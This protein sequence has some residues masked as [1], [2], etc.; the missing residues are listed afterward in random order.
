MKKIFISYRRQDSGPF[1]GRIHDQLESK[2][3]DRNVFCD[4]HDIPAGSDFRAVLNREVSQCDV[5][6]AV[7]GR[8]WAGITDAKGNRRL[9]DPNDFVRIEIELAL[10]NPKIIVI[11]VLVDNAVMPVEQDLP[12]SLR[13]LCYRN[14]VKVRPDPDFSNDM[15]NLLRCIKPAPG[16]LSRWQ[17]LFGAAVLIAGIFLFAMFRGFFKDTAA[18]ESVMPS[19]AAPQ[20]Q[21]SP[22]L[23]PA[24]LVEPVEPG[25]ILVLVAQ[26]EKIGS[27]ERDVTR[28][29]VDD[30]INRFEVEVPAANVRIRE[31]EMVITSNTEALKIAEQTQAVL[32]IW[33]QY[34]D[35][36]AT[37]NV[38]LGSLAS[39]P[40][41]ALERGFL[42]RAIN[43]RVKIKNEREETL[44]YQV[45]GSLILLHNAE[46]EMVTQMI[47]ILSFDLLDAPS[48]EMIG[49][50]SAVHVQKSQQAFISD[51]PLALAE[52]NQAID[53]GA[54]N[55]LFYLFRGLLYQ[56]LGDF[57]S[58]D[59]DLDTALLLAPEG[60][61]A[62]YHVKGA[63][64]LILNNLP[65][66]I[67]SYSK[68][69]EHT[70]DDWYPYNQRGYL[71]FL[72]GQ[73][74]LARADIDQ[75]IALKP[76]TEWPYMWSALIALRQ[77]R[78]ED[79]STMMASLF[80]EQP[81]PAFVDRLL[82]ALYGA[83]NAKLLG[84]SMAA[85]G[86]LSLGQYNVVLQDTDNVL[87][88]MPAYPEMYMLRGLSY[89][90][91]DKYADAE[92]AYTQGLTLDPSFTLLH[93]LRAEMRIKSGD[94]AGA[95]EDITAVQQS[96]LA[97]NFSAYLAAAQSGQFSCKQMFKTK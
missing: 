64:S 57:A 56:G 5:V 49:N 55:P 27:Q 30:L 87:A 91:L 37:V 28:F 52:I 85:M 54:D 81:N 69:I 72:A 61:V 80:Q 73:Y 66:G 79:A 42:E 10:N 77:G 38:Q 33:G 15:H 18:T 59:Q 45:L 35:E 23:T 74:D 62:P 46:N 16:I 71:Y 83:Q 88:V 94:T 50:S 13:E 24:P 76:E 20:T 12:Q 43:V 51:K 90:N 75:A 25:Q 26:I 7:I 8:Q 47:L 41:V 29:I 31:Y 2:F 4:V 44:A 14:A 60:W 21:N 67:E 22:T 82:T 84:D 36:S 6:L 1:V 11:P 78:L 70:P 17:M 34:D 89:C 96:P 40:N 53:L 58:S 92:A 3:G 95:A 68:V 97:E 48:P 39:L 65:V 86:H 9:E 93:L 32:V 19:P 63:Q